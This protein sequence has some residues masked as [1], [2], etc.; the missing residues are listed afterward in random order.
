MDKTQFIKCLAGK[1]S[2]LNA[3]KVEHSIQ[4]ILDA[5]CGTLAKGRRIEIR[6]FGS[7][8]LKQLPP[9]QMRNPKNGFTLK[10]PPRHVPHYKPAKEL[11][12]RT[13]KN[14]VS[15]IPE[16]SSARQISS[17]LLDHAAANDTGETAIYA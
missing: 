8:S 12:L 5:L 4:T 17:E 14:N 11:N 7:F 1:H 9:A 16:I 10:E 3:K 6:G 2:Q 13:S 15:G